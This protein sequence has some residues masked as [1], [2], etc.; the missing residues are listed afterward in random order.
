MFGDT[1]YRYPRLTITVL[2]E[3][4]QS[5]F[6]MGLCFFSSLYLLTIKMSH[7]SKTVYRVLYRRIPFDVCCHLLCRQN[8]L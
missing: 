1:A 7:L 2:N 6:Y 5:P 3:K 8:T 4:K